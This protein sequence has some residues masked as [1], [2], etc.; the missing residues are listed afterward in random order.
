MAE[1]SIYRDINSFNLSYVKDIVKKWVRNII[2][3]NVSSKKHSILR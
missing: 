1:Y 3:Q 2:M